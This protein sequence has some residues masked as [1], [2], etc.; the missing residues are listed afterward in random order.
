MGEPTNQL[1]EPSM[2]K[3]AD[4]VKE[5]SDVEV[6]SKQQ[7]RSKAVRSRIYG[8]AV[9][10]EAEPYNPDPAPNFRS[11]RLHSDGIKDSSFFRRQ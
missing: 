6:N 10:Y 7:L 3:K 5:H 9:P 1:I 4:R 8:K 2:K 11:P